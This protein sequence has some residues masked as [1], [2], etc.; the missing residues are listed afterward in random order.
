MRLQNYCFFLTYASVWLFFLH[1]YAFFL[2]FDI[3]SIEKRHALKS[4]INA[5]S[6]P[7]HISPARDY[8]RSPC[9]HALHF[10]PSSLVYFF[11]LASFVWNSRHRRFSPSLALLPIFSLLRHVFALAS[12]ASASPARF[13]LNASVAHAGCSGLFTCGDVSVLLFMEFCLLC[14]IIPPHLCLLCGMPCR[15]FRP[16]TRHPMP[17][18]YVP[19]KERK[20]C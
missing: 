8:M 13:G 6:A 16:L 3:P 14:G 15:P 10:S 11:S 12:R 18:Q 7:F 17:A 20:L 9:V 1:F 2:K 5:L 19:F 4:Q